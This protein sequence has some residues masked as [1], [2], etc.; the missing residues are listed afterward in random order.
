MLL[1]APENSGASGS[2]LCERHFQA[3]LYGHFSRYNSAR[4]VVNNLKLESEKNRKIRPA[5]RNWC[6]DVRSCHR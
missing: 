6:A 1:A 5:I 3:A 2:T 4:D